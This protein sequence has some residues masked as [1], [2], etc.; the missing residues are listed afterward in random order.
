MRETDKSNKGWSREDPNSY[1]IVA[2]DP[3]PVFESAP[4]GGRT[5]IKAGYYKWTRGGLRGI[6]FGGSEIST[7]S[8]Q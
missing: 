5:T 4:F 2:Y 1:A 7:Q 8:W 3:D 6:D